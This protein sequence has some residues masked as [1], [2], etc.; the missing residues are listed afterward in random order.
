M[1]YFMTEQVRERPRE[2]GGGWSFFR[3]LF[4]FLFT[5][6]LLVAAGLAVNNVYGNP[7]EVE[8][9]AGS[10]AC[11]GQ[12]PTCKAQFTFWQRSPLGHSFTMYTPN[13]THG[14]YCQREWILLGGWSCS[15]TGQMT[16][17]NDDHPPAGTSATPRRVITVTIPMGPAPTAKPKAS[18]TAAPKASGSAAGDGSAPR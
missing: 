13:G 12:G 10:A 8:S 5:A 11:Q 18:A 2:G 4:S 16:P 15:A 17:A 1:M 9:L 3:S 7:V 14:V 6:A